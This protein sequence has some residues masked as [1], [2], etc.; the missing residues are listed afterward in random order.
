MKNILTTKQKER[1]LRNIWLAHDG[2]W[3]LK[4]AEKFGFDTATNVNLAVQEFVGEKETEL[5]LA[6]SGYQIKDIEDVRTI[7]EATCLLNT[8]EGH[9]TE[10]KVIDNNRAIL[11][12]RD[13]YVHKMVSK[14]GNIDI[15]RC[16]S[17]VRCHSWLK[18]LAIGG[19]VIRDADIDS[20]RGKCEIIFE[21]SFQS[22]K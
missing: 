11:Y 1:L 17:L 10:V 14:A 18:G 6:E 12:T 20:C 13:C 9:K 16:S 4:T 2:R 15:H 7:I 22:R 8:P 5:L 3:L 21:I 19:K